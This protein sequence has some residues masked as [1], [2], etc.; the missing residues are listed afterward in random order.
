MEDTFRGPGCY[1][2]RDFDVYYVISLSCSLRW[3]KVV[4]IFYKS[5]LSLGGRSTLNLS[6]FFL[7]FIFIFF[8]WPLFGLFAVAEMVWL[9]HLVFCLSVLIL[10]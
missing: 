7:V 1:L 5:I 10:V 6:F 3:M 9:I 4:R 8:F 2:V